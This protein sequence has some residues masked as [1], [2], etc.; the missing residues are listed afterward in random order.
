[1][2]ARNGVVETFLELVAID[3]PSGDEAAIAEYVCRR[4][5]A[6]GVD[7][8][9]DNFGNIIARRGAGDSL[10]LSAHL[11]TVE[12]GRGVR[13]IMQN[14][15]IR[16]D[17][18]TVLGADNKAAIAAILEVMEQMP[19]ADGVAVEAIF[20]LGEEAGNLGARN[21]D[22]SLLRSR[23]GFCFDSSNPLGTI[24]TG[25]PFYERFD[26]A[27]MGRAAHSSRPEEALNLLPLVGELL[28]KLSLGAIDK[29]TVANIGMVTAGVARNVVPGEAH[30]AGEVRSFSGQGIN[31]YLA[32]VED[33]VRHVPGDSCKM[34]RERENEGYVLSADDPL[35]R[36]TEETVRAAGFT[37]LLKRTWGCADNCIFREKGLN[38]LNLG[39]G[40]RRI[41]T[42]EE[43]IRVDE[44]GGLVDIIQALVHKRRRVV[45]RS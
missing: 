25:A 38:V 44:L 7:Y 10:V 14:N 34:T 4:L 2:S 21:L 5:K 6:H 41:H 19:V 39:Y 29:D 42:T 8:E 45:T 37:P 16:S 18:K 15:T 32:A 40:A 28:G 43:E 30:L 26:I 17:G 13:A 12:P 23:E 11:D 27:I 33:I 36:S 3:S 20:T 31:D 9:K 35:L 24:I 1:M 22:Y